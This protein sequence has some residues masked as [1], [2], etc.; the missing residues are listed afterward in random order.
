M[1]IFF[2]RFGI[3]LNSGK[4]PLNCYNTCFRSNKPK[5]ETTGE[6]YMHVVLFADSWKPFGHLQ[7]LLS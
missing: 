5:Y 1:P 2:E 4:T 7:V 3:I 6:N